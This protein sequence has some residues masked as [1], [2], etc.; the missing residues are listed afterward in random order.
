MAVLR[1]EAYVE[2]KGATVTEH[3]ASAASH[4]STSA[5]M[6]NNCAG[7]HADLFLTLLWRSAAFLTVTFI[8]LL[9]FFPYGPLKN[10]SAGFYCL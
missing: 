2:W 4:H 9:R 7:S 1:S 10:V 3:R 8:R 6:S 5:E